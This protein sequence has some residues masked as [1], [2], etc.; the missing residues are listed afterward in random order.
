MHDTTWAGKKQTTVNSDGVPIGMKQILLE[1]GV[2]SVQKSSWFART[3]RMASAF[4][5]TGLKTIVEHYLKG[6]GFQN[7]TAN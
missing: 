4:M 1:R 5:L 2:F 7:S 3:T 6:R